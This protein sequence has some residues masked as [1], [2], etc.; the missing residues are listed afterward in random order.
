[1]TSQIADYLNTWIPGVKGIMVTISANHSCMQ[2]R[3]ARMTGITETSAIRG[4]F[5]E[6]N[7]LKNEVLQLLNKK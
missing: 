1:M 2:I 4:I 6:D 7:N 3:G 5:C